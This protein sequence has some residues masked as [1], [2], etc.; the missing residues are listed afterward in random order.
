MFV[1]FK[2]I[3]TH[4]RREGWKKGEREGEQEGRREGRREGGIAR[5][6][7]TGQSIFGNKV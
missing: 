1:L 7:T 2:Q 6:K 5:Y 4:R 3:H